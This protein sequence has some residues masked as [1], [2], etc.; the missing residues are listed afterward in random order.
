E[1]M[2]F[3]PLHVN[4]GTRESTRDY[5]RATAAACPQNLVVELDALAT[6]VVLDDQRRAVAVEYQKGARL[7]RASAHP[8]PKPEGGERRTIRARREII[9]CG[10]VFN[11]PQLLLLSGIGPKAEIE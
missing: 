9:L 4:R 10:G 5:V 7:Y 3:V 6:R 1:G 2:V 11:S 8:D